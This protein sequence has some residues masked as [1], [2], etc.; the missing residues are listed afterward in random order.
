[1]WSVVNHGGVA[2]RGVRRLLAGAPTAC[3]LA[4][5]APSASSAAD[6]TA[7][8]VTERLFRA[9]AGLATELSGRDL[10]ELDL[11]GLD[12]KRAR[13]TGSNLYGVDLTSADLSGVDLSG[14]RLDR[15]VVIRADFTRANLKGASMQRLTVFSDMRFDRAE[16]PKFTAADMSGSRLFARLDGADFRDANLTD[17]N[18][19]PYDLRGGD[20]S[21]QA[22]CVFTKSDFSRANL[23][24]AN[25]SHALMPFAN[26]TSANLRDTN[27]SHSDLS[28]ADL[29]DADVTGANLTG[30][31]LYGADLRRTRGLAEAVG[32]DFA[33]N[34][35]KALR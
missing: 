1:M 26:F 28:K 16:A 5:L 19:G 4:V 29:S 15:A 8:Q 32:L 20:I 24:R 12:F 33:V 9:E 27:L 7:R 30:T 13:L 3:V 18:F 35:D 34:L 31:D 14:T 25:L 21:V 23:E 17:A 11:S 6:L 2:V 22:R 10:S